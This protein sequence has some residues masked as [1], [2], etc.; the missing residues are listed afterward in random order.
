[1]AWSRINEYIQFTGNKSP[2]QVSVCH[3]AR[4]ARAS[5]KLFGR[6]SFL[7]S[8]IPVSNSLWRATP[9]SL[10]WVSVLCVVLLHLLH[11]L[12]IVLSLLHVLLVL[13]HVLLVVLLLGWITSLRGATWTSRAS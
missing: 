8:S 3:L 10:R 9:M 13:L 12:W 7:I 6:L 5:S 1:M 11:V 2:L 4:A